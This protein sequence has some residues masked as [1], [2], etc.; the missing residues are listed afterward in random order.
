MYWTSRA[1]RF[2]VKKWLE[3]EEFR[4]LLDIARYLGRIDGYSIFEIDPERIE[5]SG[6][7]IDDVRALL[8]SVD[9]IVEE[10]VEAVLSFLAESKKVTIRLGED[11]WLRIGG[12]IRLKPLIAELGLYLPYDR[13]TREYKAPAHLY[14]KLVEHFRSKGLVVEDKVGLLEGRN[15]PRKVEFKGELRPYQEEALKAWRESGYRGIIALPTGAGKTVIAI[16]GIAEL[17]KYTLVV[18]YTV[19]HIRQW[20]E[21][22]AKFSNAGGLVGAYYGGE[23]RIAPITITT[24][25]TAFRKVRLFAPLFPLIIFDEA[26]HL[27]ADKFRAIATGMPA[28]YRLGLSATPERPDGRHE[29]LFPLLG[30]VIYRTTPGELTRQ[31]YLAPFK[32]R[33]VKVEMEPDERKRYEQLRRRYQLL[34]AG[35]TFQELLDAAKRGDPTA[36]E[37]LRVNAQMRNLIQYS[38]AKLKA[39][40]EIVRKELAKGSKIIVFTQ[41]RKQAEE[42]AKRVG[43]LLLHG[44][45]D[46]RRRVRILET[47]KRMKSGVLVLTT[48]GDEGLD[49]PDAN[50]GILVSGTSSP[51]QFIQR[52]GRL[53]RPSPGKREA[54]LYEVVM[55]G[56]SEEFQ[57]R[58]RRMLR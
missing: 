12:R 22:I 56:T 8:S 51:R 48:V 44:G 11:G 41:Y 5:R 40:N 30:G 43:G 15:L 54:I 39:V 21:A 27:P 49:I 50:V 57:S 18:V 9:G 34:A 47:F 6:Y 45:L 42:I 46:K 37:A 38:E 17:S 13:E 31:G 19:E 26:H 33:R 10:D 4:R 58:K 52:L 2:R 28:P 20:S 1:P 14:R 29:E 24:Y 7:T 23:K 53:L 16:A 55:A 25:Q 36:I 35:R 3:N 32:V